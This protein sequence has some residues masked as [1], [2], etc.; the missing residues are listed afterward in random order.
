MIS[1][2]GIPLSH[3]Q[4]D[5]VDHVIQNSYA[6][7]TVASAGAGSGKTRTMVA[8]VLHLIKEKEDVNVDD[9][10]LITFTNKAA[11]EMRERLEEALDKHIQKT[12]DQQEAEMWFEQTERLANCF[13]GTIHRFCTMILKQHGYDEGV[14]HETEMML[15][16]VQF[17]DALNE[18]M[19]WAVDN[20]DTNILFN[21][22]NIPWEPYE[23]EKFFASAYEHVR[24]NGRSINHV[25][26]KTL[27]QPEDKN[28]DNLCY[29]IAVA[30]VLQKVDEIYTKI[31]E[32][33]GSQDSNDL[34]RK[35]AD[36]LGKHKSQIGK[37]MKRKYK[38]L[39]VDEF[40]DTDRTQL[41]I[42]KTLIPYLAHVLVVGDRKQSIYGFRGAQPSVLLELA[43][44]FGMEPLPLLASRRPTKNLF[45]VQDTLFSNM[46]NRYTFL[47]EKLKEPEDAYEPN[48]DI[49][50][51]EYIHIEETANDE[52][53][54]LK[55]IEKVHSYLDKQIDQ[56]NESVRP[57]QYSDI[58]ILF[59]TNRQMEDYKV[60]FQR[61][62]LPV[63]ID[64]GG[65]FFQK[66][67]IIH[68]YYMLNAILNYPNDTTLD[69]VMGTPF[70]PVRPPVTV[71]QTVEASNQL[72]TWLKNTSSVERWYNGMME[73]RE[74]IKSDLVPQL[75][76]RLYEFTGVR[77]YYAKKE[78]Y[79]AIA[80]LEKL[81]SWSRDMFENA[82]ALTMQSFFERLQMA[83]LTEEKMD[84]ADVG[85]E[86]PNEI[87]FSTVH[88][89]K[90]LEY[91]IIIMSHLQ[92]PLKDDFK[93]P[94]F[95]DIFD[96]QEEKSDWGIDLDIEGFG[97]SDRF[98]EWMEE[99]EGEFYAEEARV[100]YVA[101]TRAQHAMC[102]VTRGKK[103]PS[104]LHSKFWS[105]K[106]EILTEIDSLSQ[107]GDSYVKVQM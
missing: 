2:G 88:S 87:V 92:R 90:G 63:K 41:Q 100:F 24:N 62:G 60:F 72:S 17:N 51:M 28:S 57:V 8:A 6:K 66:S 13:I 67:E 69:L 15:S 18:A 102:F 97:Q 23:W 46:S 82:E 85:A 106:D 48:D 45:R 52:T 80:N 95:F 31:K 12:T 27:E 83:I 104:Q 94:K 26:H 49:I 107:L 53:L 30:N 96:P 93:V 47:K 89:S 7:P 4:A 101:V 1:R 99:F 64:T 21:Y 42:V 40:Q 38:Y 33:Q 71:H 29:R 61:A 78:N 74:S 70:F 25:V 43:N 84:E 9:F 39:F 56:P 22:E 14:P 59:R 103:Q 77:E 98:N 50:P 3:E 11:D 76:T 32:E 65:N 86:E 55:T 16:K 75:L 105:W 35:C 79:Q 37:I 36:L 10:A 44:D 91:P 54:I 58:C 81:V 20:P 19:D 68:C 5:I 34:L 73:I